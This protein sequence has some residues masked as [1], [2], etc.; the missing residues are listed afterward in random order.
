MSDADVAVDQQALLEAAEDAG[1]LEA[2][3][4]QI[5]AGAPHAYR[6]DLPPG[7]D[8]AEEIAKLVLKQFADMAMAQIGLDSKFNALLQISAQLQAIMQSL[9]SG[10]VRLTTVNGSVMAGLPRTINA[11]ID[12]ETVNGRVDTDFKVKISGKISTRHL[13]GIIG[14]GGPT[15]K[16]VTVN[17]SI[18]LHDAGM[19]K[20]GEH[21]AH[22][23]EPRAPRA[24]RA[25]PVPDRP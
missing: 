14:E 9:S 7:F 15:L 11:N 17:G 18:G 4:E 24:P 16:L 10:D 8:P 12:A 13:R 23:A 19:F 21:P 1:G 5:P 22:P 3:A 20:P 6:G 2:L 25:A